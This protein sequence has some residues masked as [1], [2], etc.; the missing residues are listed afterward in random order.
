MAPAC[1]V[2]VVRQYVQHFYGLFMQGVVKI[3]EI[4]A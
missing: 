2:G 3:T 1:R 4:M